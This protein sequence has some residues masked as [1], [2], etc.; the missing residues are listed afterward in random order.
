MW[1]PG[2]TFRGISVHSIATEPLLS[3]SLHA[4]DH[5][6][7]HPSIQE[8]TRLH[9]NPVS[10]ATPHCLPGATSHLSRAWEADLPLL[11]T[12]GPTGCTSP[13]RTARVP[14]PHDGWV[15]N[16]FFPGDHEGQGPFQGLLWLLSSLPHHFPQGTRRRLPG[17]VRPLLSHSLHSSRTSPPGWWAEQHLPVHSPPLLLCSQ[18]VPGLHRALQSYLLSV[19]LSWSSQGRPIAACA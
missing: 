19:P 7:I 5:P 18:W 15:W 16:V 1:G 12:P 3:A 4:Q 6:S 14:S 9:L 10:F 11:G 13:L 8:V 2:I 17:P